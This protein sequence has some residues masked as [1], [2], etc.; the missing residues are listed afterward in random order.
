M[1]KYPTSTADFNEA[2]TLLIEGGEK[3]TEEIARW[4]LVP[5]ELQADLE[6]FNTAN[7]AQE[8]AKSAQQTASVN[9]ENTKKK[10]QASMARWVS[11]LEGNYGKT[12][13]KLLEFGLAPR[14][15]NPHKGPRT[16]EQK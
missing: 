16:T 15:Y 14:Q 12:S 8:A 2:A 1:R 7:G 6:A 9:W 4:G 3:N 10:L 11:T 13:E 5:A